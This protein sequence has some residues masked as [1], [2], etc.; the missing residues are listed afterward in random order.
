MWNGSLECDKNVLPVLLALSCHAIA[1]K[2]VEPS[3]YLLLPC[4]YDLTWYDACFITKMTSY[5]GLF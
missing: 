4:Y 3:V 1:I 2:N 5:I